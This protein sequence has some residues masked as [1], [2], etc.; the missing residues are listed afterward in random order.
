MPKSMKCNACGLVN[1]QEKAVCGRC[2]QAF[3]NSEHKSSRK[4][5][6]SRGAKSG[7]SLYTWAFIGAIA[8]AIFYFYSG[9]SSDGGK[10]VSAVN[11]NPD[12][13]QLSSQPHQ[14]RT[15]PYTDAIR[16]GPDLKASD[17]RTAEINKLM[18]PS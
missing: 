11:A 2:G 7:S 12:P 5:S 18:A 16:E 15:M 1:F 13:F 8:A 3:G 17:A 10:P 14:H 4:S 9:S 6:S